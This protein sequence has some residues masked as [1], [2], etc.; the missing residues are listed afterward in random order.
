MNHCLIE[1]KK[2]LFLSLLK[3]FLNFYTNANNSFTTVSNS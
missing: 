1:M 3:V 2:I